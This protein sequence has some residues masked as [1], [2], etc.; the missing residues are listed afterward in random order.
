[1]RSLSAVALALAALAP[2]PSAGQR[3][4][5]RAA[6][7]GAR[8]VR[9]GDGSRVVE[10]GGVRAALD[11]PPAA[12]VSAVRELAD[13][14][15]VAATVRDDAGSELF[16]ARGDARGGR[17]APPPGDR[18]GALRED[19]EPLVDRGALAGL[20]WLE[21]DDSDR[22]AVRYARWTADGFA[23][24]MTVSPAGAGSQLALEAV[25]LADG[26]ALLVWAGFDGEDDEIW[27]SVGDGERWSPP[28]R[29]GGDNA[30]PDITPAVIADGAGAWV[31]WSRFDGSEYRLALARFRDGRFGD[32]RWAAPA[33]SLYPTFET[34]ADGIA[35]LYRDART[36]SW[37]LAELGGD[38]VPG[39]V[40]RIEGPSDQRP[41]V[42]IEVNRVAWRWAARDAVSSW[43]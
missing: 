17:P 38:G 3:I 35:V 42:R 20:A 33:G 21:G 10:S 32:A 2:A 11:L 30:V 31:A 34:S 19:P 5:A 8:V 26:R 36:G 28:A 22:L 1:V 29:V 12:S 14:W 24:P 9:L 41:A 25:T 18:R 15:L 23:A 39:R 27:A 40:A 4:E 37:A 7:D 43:E 6:S 16:L 13:G